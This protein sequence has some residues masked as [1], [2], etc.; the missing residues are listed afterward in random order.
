MATRK[1]TWVYSP[2]KPKKIKPKVPEKMIQ[3]LQE[4]GNEIV[5]KIFKPNYLLPVS[6]EQTLNQLIDIYAK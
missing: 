3:Y 6:E 5:E 1:K 4:K 2:P